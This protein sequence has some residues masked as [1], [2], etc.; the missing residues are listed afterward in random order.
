MSQ[1]INIVTVIS[2]KVV[3]C[4]CMCDFVMFIVSSCASKNDPDIIDFGGS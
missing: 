2:N 1:R 3:M 4:V